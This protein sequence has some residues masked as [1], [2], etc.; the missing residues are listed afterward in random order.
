MEND[1]ILKKTKRNKKR[2]FFCILNIFFVVYA[3]F[4]FN[5]YFLKAPIGNKMTVIHVAPGQTVEEIASLLEER[6]IIRYEEL[7]KIIVKI[8]NRDKRIESGDYKFNKDLSVFQVAWQIST[9]YHNVNPIKILLREGLTNEQMAL[10][11]ADKMSFFRKD[12]FIANTKQGYLFPDTY[13]LYSLMTTEEIIDALQSNFNKQ[14]SKLKPEIDQ[15]KRSFEDILI[16]ASI[17][18]KE[19][20]GASD[21]NMISG[22]LWKRLGM[23]MPLQADA[24]PITYDRPGLPEFP[25]CNPG[26]VSIK[27]ALTPEESNYLFYL[28]DNN[29][30]V[31]YATN[32]DQ[33]K[34]NIKEYLK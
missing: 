20:S 17:I 2:L 30:I 9:N 34:K 32:Y 12:I 31:H 3:I 25:I 22:I 5:Y 15:S 4:I 18:E 28:H 27:A 7:F 33:H 10:I 16:M 1:L 8:I 19:A 23:G 29:G 21:A 13:L 14:I 6:K 26:L 24:S 11:L